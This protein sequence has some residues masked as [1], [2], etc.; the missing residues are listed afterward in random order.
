M[1]QWTDH[2]IGA[3]T[4]AAAVTESVVC[5]RAGNSANLRTGGR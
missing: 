2:P 3:I 5:L 4:A 1:V